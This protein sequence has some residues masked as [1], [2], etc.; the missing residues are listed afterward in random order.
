MFSCLHIHRFIRFTLLVKLCVC[1]CSIKNYLLTYLLLVWVWVTLNTNFRRKLAWCTNHCWCQK[2]RVIALSCGI[3]ISA[4]HCLVWSQSMRVTDRRTDRQNYYSRDRTTIAA[5]RGKYPSGSYL[6]R[7]KN[8]RSNH[9]RI[10][11]ASLRGGFRGA[12]EVVI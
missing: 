10:Y 9:N 5:S 12:E 7:V 6:P 11:I 2:T 1:Q 3:K 4:V 8:N